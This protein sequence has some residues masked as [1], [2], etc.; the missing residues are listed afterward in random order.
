[1]HRMDFAVWF[2]CFFFFCW[3]CFSCTHF[4]YAYMRA[5]LE[6]DSAR[7][8]VCMCLYDFVRLCVVWSFFLRIFTAIFSNDASHPFGYWCRMVSMHVFVAFL[9]KNRQ[10]ILVF[11]SIFGLPVS[12]FQMIN[13]ATIRI[14][15]TEWYDFRP[16]RK[17]RKERAFMWMAIIIFF[18]RFVG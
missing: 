3:L 6:V 11:R 1:M 14:I 18:S 5:C 10:N 16:K 12:S 9:F 4:C 8:Y 13:V 7:E 15:P 17:K 2:I